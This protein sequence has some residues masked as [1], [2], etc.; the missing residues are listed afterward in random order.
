MQERRMLLRI[1]GK[2]GGQGRKM[3]GRCYKIRNSNKYCFNMAVNQQY[4]QVLFGEN[5]TMASFKRWLNVAYCT[6]SH[7]YAFL[8]LLEKSERGPFV[9]L[10]PKTFPEK[11][12]ISVKMLVKTFSEKFLAGK[13]NILVS[14]MKMCLIVLNSGN[15]KSSK[16]PE[17]LV[18]FT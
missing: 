3:I 18:L 1:K 2:K 7:L 15:K 5:C 9:Q 10:Y 13:L 11:N 12:S 17:Q 8:L 14:S 6:L 4:L 16:Y